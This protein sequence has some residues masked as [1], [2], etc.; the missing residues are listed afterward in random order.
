MARIELGKAVALATEIAEGA[1]AQH[2]EAVDAEGRW[3]VES[4]RALQAELGGLVVPEQYGGLGHGLLAVARVGEATGRVC[5]S[6][7][8]CFG[9]HHVGT[10]MIAIKAYQPEQWTYLERIAAGR[11]LT[12]LAVSEPGSGSEFWLPQTTLAPVGADR[13]RIDG[14]K[15]FVTN[16]GH[17][18]SYVISTVAADPGAPPG[19]F[20]CVII[21]G[22]S[23]GLTWGPTWDGFGMRGNSSRGV[24]L[25]GVEVP[26]AHL[27]GEEGDQIWYLF[28]AC[29]PHFLTAMAGTYLGVAAA[30]LDEA[31]DHLRTRVYAHSGRA[32]SNVDVLQHRLGR[33]WS[34][35]EAARRL[36]YYAAEAFDS[37]SADALPALCSAK[38]EVADTA[39]DIVNAAMTVVGGIGYGTARA[40]IQRRLRDARA[41]HVMSPTTDMLRTWTGRALL[42]A[43]LLEG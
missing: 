9:M 4:L 8:I 13:L 37:G 43:P 7:S 18:D 35:V 5:A 2:A 34:R 6:S 42:D 25:S 28:N 24:T 12:T 33:M 26:R 36:L 30:A 23:P 29:A 31:R 39:E 11:H 20:S 19:Q 10:A 41:A 22:D 27:L 14:Q 16:G 17:A 40:P 1:L 38:A 32:L 3:P 15:S 21:P